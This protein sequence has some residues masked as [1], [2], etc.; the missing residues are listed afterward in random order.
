MSNVRRTELTSFIQ[1]LDRCIDMCALIHMPTNLSDVLCE[2]FVKHL[3]YIGPNRRHNL[4]IRIAGSE[5]VRG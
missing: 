5:I 1:T 2:H 3:L 4:A